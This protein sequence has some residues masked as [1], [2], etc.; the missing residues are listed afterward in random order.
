MHI[1]SYIGYDVILS[2]NLIPSPVAFQ[3]IAL[4]ISLSGHLSFTQI[5]PVAHAFIELY[6]Y[7]ETQDHILSTMLSLQYFLAFYASATI[8]CSSIM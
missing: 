8:E 5:V 6:R 2:F 7:D 1:T 3:W 4:L